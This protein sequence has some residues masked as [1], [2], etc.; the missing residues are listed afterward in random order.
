VSE[1]Q[2]I[3]D[4][5]HDVK[6]AILS[7]YGEMEI[8]RNIIKDLNKQ[9]AA[10]EAEQEKTRGLLQNHLQNKPQEPEKSDFPDKARYDAE[11]ARYHKAFSTWSA[12]RDR[13]EGLLKSLKAAIPIL[14]K[15]IEEK[16]ERLRELEAEVE[17]L[18]QDAKE[19]MELAYTLAREA[20]PREKASIEAEIGSV[21]NNLVR[22]QQVSRETATRI[23]KN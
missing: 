20:S 4:Q 3:Y 7:L 18:K 9:I 14:K 17:R 22:E 13:I 5:L 21:R 1:I 10:N 12:E 16:N 23:K 11:L 15:K 6:N 8:I 19:L 2:K